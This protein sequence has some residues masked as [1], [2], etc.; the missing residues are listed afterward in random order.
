MTFQRKQLGRKGEEAAAQYLINKGCALLCRNFTC[1]IGEI[2]LVVLDKEAL[3][4]VEVRSRSGSGY[5][6]AQESVTKRKQQKLRQLAWYYLQVARKTECCCRFDVIA[7]SFDGEG[8]LISL[9][10]IIN[11]F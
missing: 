4:F 1:N 11:A 5:G 8:I 9:D 6:L 3:V 10:H 7:V 2:D